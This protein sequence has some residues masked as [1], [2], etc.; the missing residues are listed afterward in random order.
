MR[1]I[2]GSATNGDPRGDRQADDED[3]LD[4]RARRAL[5]LGRRA[6]E[7]R[8]EPG[9]PR[10]GDEHGH[11]H[12]RLE[13]LRA[14]AVPADDRRRRHDREH[15]RVDPEVEHEED[16]E[17]PVG[18]ALAGHV[19]ELPRSRAPL[20][21]DVPAQPADVQDEH[22]GR[23]DEPAP[24]EA[25]RTEARHGERDA[26]QALDRLVDDVRV[27]QVL[28]PL[29]GLEAGLHG[30]GEQRED[31][32][33]SGEIQ[34]ERP[35]AP[36]VGEVGPDRDGDHEHRRQQQPQQGAGTDQPPGI[37][38]RHDDRAHQ[39]VP[40]AEAEHGGQQA[41]DRPGR[42]DEPHPGRPEQPGYH[43]GP[44]QGHR[45]GHELAARH[46]GDVPSDARPAERGE[47][48]EGVLGGCCRRQIGHRRAQSNSGSRPSRT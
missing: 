35:V 2:A 37:G 42:D 15:R 33:P 17:G 39:V 16:A 22:D 26:Q 8:H 48:R 44:G 29:D 7:D 5:Q 41:G 3:D 10:G 20:H 4:R 23:H 40:G 9:K 21:A 38:G 46:G 19:G 12:E 1:L 24:G 34:R 32:G 25:D 27:G 11:H 18:H 43:E 31:S 45:P 47:R 14:H 28:H 30:L 6:L 13:Q 36:V